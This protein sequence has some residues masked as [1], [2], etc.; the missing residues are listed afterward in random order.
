MA[1]AIKDKVTILNNKGDVVFEG[2]LPITNFERD[3]MSGCIVADCSIG[4]KT[5]LVWEID[6]KWLGW[7]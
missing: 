3:A 5:V 1:Y 2:L 6:N 7:I 4:E